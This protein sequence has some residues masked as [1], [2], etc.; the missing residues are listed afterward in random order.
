MIRPTSLPPPLRIAAIALMMVGGGM[1]V[2][3][4]GTIEDEAAFLARCSVETLRA[5]PS[6]A[7]WVGD[8]C[9]VRWRMAAAAGPMAEAILALAPV[10]GGAPPSRDEVRARLPMVR[11]SFGGSEG[12]LDDVAVRLADAGSGVGFHWRMQGSDGRYDVIEALRIR[13]VTLRT[14]GCPQYPGASMG[15]EKVMQAELA[16]RSP[17][18][19]TVYSRPA[20]TG[21]EPGLYGVA[22]DFSEPFPD[23]AAL[24]A[25]RYPGGGGCAYAVDP[26]GWTADC[27]D[28]E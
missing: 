18:T 28:P 15:R 4:A 1:A 7:S 14:L 26:T 6:A 9:S 22:V 25:G 13:G 11:W 2:A 21:I 20:P 12:S 10:K 8:H 27:P 24:R 16:G 23:M 3:G 17:F 5:Q 19:L